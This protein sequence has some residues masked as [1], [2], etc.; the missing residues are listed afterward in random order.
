MEREIRLRHRQGHWVWILS[1]TQVIEWDAE[2]RP[3]KTS[4]VNLDISAAKALESAL[5]RER[6]ALARIMETSVSGI[7]AVDGVG[8]VVFAN[9]A[10]EQVLGRPVAAGDHL[11]S[12]LA[13]ADVTDLEGQ[14][15]SPD[16]YP[17]ARAL[18]GLS[19]QQDVRQSI[20]WPDGTRRVLSLN[21]AR[22]SAPG[23]D[24]AAVCSLTDIT[25]AVESETRLRAAMAAAEAASQAKSDFLAAM[26]HEMRTPLNGILGM[27]GHLER[28]TP[29]S[30]LRGQ[31]AVIRSSGEHLLA[32]INDILD[33]AKIEAGQLTLDPAPLRVG[34]LAERV[35]ATHRV[36]ARDK[37]LQ[38][39][40]RQ[41]GTEAAMLRRGD[42][43]RLMQIL[44][45]LVGNAIKF[46]EQ[47][48]VTLHLDVRSDRR[49]VIEV[50]DTGIGM[51]E[52][53]I[54]RVF[55]AFVQGQGG[56]ARRYGGT[57]LGLTI[58]HRLTALMG[59]EVRL[60][61]R[62][63]GGLLVRLDLDLPQVSPDEASL[64]PIDAPLPPLP[65]LRIVAAEDNA[66]NRLI[67]HS[68]LASMGIEATILPSGEAAI[69]HWQ[70]SEVD[71][72]LLDIAMPGCDGLATLA[73]LRRLAADQGRAMPCVLAVTAN[74]MTHQV[75][76]YLAS[77]FAGVVPK[78][79]RPEDL[80]RALH[81][82]L[83]AGSGP[84]PRSLPR[85]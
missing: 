62:P 81:A 53:D 79:L 20:A 14:P 68:I 75:E 55:G 24:L 41:S 46:T 17:L 49:L 13:G 50:A 56:I 11:P 2:G 29:D 23:T 71:V 42:E 33:L 10:A 65:P 21:A 69:A 51:A 73:A 80:N 43:K 58:V 26:S 28:Q 27:A 30:D 12:I 4:G 35:L 38:L 31:L 36:Q 78:P 32:V 39:D 63:G 9:A 72:M 34:D 22:L 25:D 77:G 37:G 70:A 52:A 54:A 18:A 61:P 6:D 64:A 60:I 44:H 48:T 1:R 8:R 19:V 76:S 3:V 45:N 7:V 40:L 59:G 57:G 83:A 85:E 15:V 67:L 74:A 84:S 5:A 66:T 47:G 16:T 82:A